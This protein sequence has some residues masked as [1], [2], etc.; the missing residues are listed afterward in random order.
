MTKWTRLINF[1]NNSKQRHKEEA[2][3]AQTVNCP[4]VCRS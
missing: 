2:H 4:S 3:A 1:V